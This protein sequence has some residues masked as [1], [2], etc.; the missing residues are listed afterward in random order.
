[1]IKANKIGE[2]KWFTNDFPV[3]VFVVVFW[4]WCF[5]DFWFWCGWGLREAPG[6]LL[7]CGGTKGLSGETEEEESSEWMAE[8]SSLVGSCPWDWIDNEEGFRA[9]S[10][11][12]A[13]DDDGCIPRRCS[14]VE[15]KARLM[16]AYLTT[17]L[18]YES[19]KI[20]DLVGSE[21]R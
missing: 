14:N 13:I 7:D 21:A 12:S 9:A 11:D 2:I 5:L 20:Q 15:D 3:G 6:E 8:L 16:R 10:V 18:I 4:L 17:G 1:M 19:S